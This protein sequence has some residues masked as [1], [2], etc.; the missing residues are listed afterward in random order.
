MSQFKTTEGF[1]VGDTLIIKRPAAPKADEVTITEIV[2]KWGMNVETQDGIGWIVGIS[3][4]QEHRPASPG[5]G[6][7]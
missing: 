4:V 7:R 1:A 2:S 5:S 3:T 6:P